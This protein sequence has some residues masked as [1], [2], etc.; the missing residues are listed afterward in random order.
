[1]RMSRRP[2]VHKLISQSLL[3]AIAIFGSVFVAAQTG[4]P[5]QERPLYVATNGDDSWS[6][7][8]PVPNGSKTDGPLATIEASRDRIRA[9]RR[10]RAIH[11]PITVIIRGGRYE[12][13]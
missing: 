12:I 8:L 2:L 6:G 1:M 7:R 13:S 11:A 5:T 9:A 10:N 3:G 4:R